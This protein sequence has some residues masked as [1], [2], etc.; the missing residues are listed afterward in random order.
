MEKPENLPETE[1]TPETARDH[2]IEKIVQETAERMSLPPGVI[3]RIIDEEKFG[4]AFP[5]ESWLTPYRIREAL[6]KWT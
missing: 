2:E 1:S 6:R 5:C 4:A 3:D